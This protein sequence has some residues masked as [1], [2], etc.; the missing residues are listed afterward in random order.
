MKL[1]KKASFKLLMILLFFIGLWCFSSIYFDNYHVVQ[2]GVYALIAIVFTLNYRNISIKN[3]ITAIIL[4]VVTMPLDLYFAIITSITY[5]GASSIYNANKNGIL[6]INSSSKKGIIESGTL[7]I[8]VGVILG[9]I[10][11]F[12]FLVY[13]KILI[14]LG[15]DSH[16][17]LFPVF[18]GVTE[19]VI[20]RFFLYAICIYFIKDKEL[21]RLE[22]IL[23]YL[24][25]II[26]HLLIHYTVD[27]MEILP[28]IVLSILFG[29]PFAMIQRKQ[30][31]ISAIGAHTIVDLIRFILLGV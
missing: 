30:D 17:I 24:I 7:M 11:I 3:I 5:L 12:L 21:T 10:N 29:L 19:E 18:A 22:N 20:Y 8:S 26:P 25:M 31:L 16:R 14:N 4:G 27:T 1:Y 6:F 15:I 28:M 2:G 9:I 13:L 23:I